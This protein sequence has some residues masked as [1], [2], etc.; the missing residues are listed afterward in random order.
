MQTRKLEIKNFIDVGAFE[1][2]YTD[3]IFLMNRNC[4]VVMFEPQKKYYEFLKKKYINNP[5]IE[6]IRA[7]LSNEKKIKDLKI[8]RQE[9]T[10]TFSEF[11]KT[12]RYLNLKAIY[13]AFFDK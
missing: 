1:G 13:L 8:N 12:N 7:C 4:E 9:I 2:K 5:K 11:K 6:I 3:L 10:S